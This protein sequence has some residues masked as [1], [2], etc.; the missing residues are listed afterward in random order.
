MRRAGNAVLD[1]MP[2][3]MMSP[4]SVAQFL[5]RKEIFDLVVI[6]EASQMRPEDALGAIARARQILVVGDT[7]QLPPTSFFDRSEDDDDVDPEDVEDSEAILNVA[8]KALHPSK[9]LKWHY[10]SRH[11]NLISFSNRHFYNGD[12]IVF[13]SPAQDASDLGVKYRYI[14]DANCKSG[15]NAIEANNVANAALEHMMTK[16]HE[17]LGIVAMNKKQ[18]DLIRSEIEQMVAMNFDAADYVTK[19]I[20]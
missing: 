18:S 7:K 15:V 16:P 6:D 11:E 19:W 14:K 13:P 9:M 17:S 4:L 10:R 5:P 3:F 1:M 20:K 2:C 12:L 8:S